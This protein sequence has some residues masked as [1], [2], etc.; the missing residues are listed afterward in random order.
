M[1]AV[2]CFLVVLVLAVAGMSVR[3]AEFRRDSPPPIQAQARTAVQAEAERRQQLAWVSNWGYWL[4]SLEIPGV[5]AAPHDLLVIDSEISA[6]RVFEREYDSREV[7]RMK[8]RRDGS[9]RILLAYFS[10]G[11]AERY[12][13]YWNPDWYDA[14]KRPSWLGQ[15]NR[16]WVGNFAVQYWDPE[17]QQILFG[18]PESYLDRI[19]SRGFDGVY[20]DRADAFFQWKRLDKSAR[21]DMGLL[22]A[23]LAEHARRLNPKSLVVMQNAEELLEDAEVFNAI[24]GIAKE[25]LLFG[26]RR[27]EEPN[28]P[29]DIDWSVEL[30]QK[31]HQSGR[32]VLVV[33]Y[34][35]NPEKMATAAVRLREEGFVPYFAPRRLHCLNPPAVMS[36]TGTL[37]NHPCR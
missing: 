3:S 10:I 37:P 21:A 17:W 4:S 28:K 24:D 8:R 34:L 33:E 11:E 16:R 15:E 5:V 6:N 22:I 9:S 7:A 30:L 25:D 18:T 35:N 19:L 14:A 27:A 36:A 12:R 13:P 2:L 31:A 20:L 23:R 26:V 29:E 1:P 32:K